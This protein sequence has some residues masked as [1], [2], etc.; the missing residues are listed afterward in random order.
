MERLQE[1]Q[2]QLEREYISLEKELPQL[3]TANEQSLT[4]L[5]DHLTRLQ[6]KTHLKKRK[7][8]KEFTKIKALIAD[9]L[10]LLDGFDIKKKMNKKEPEMSEVV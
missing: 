10:L 5:L 7:D 4:H 9:T 6:I 2:S 3:D 8:S 1:V